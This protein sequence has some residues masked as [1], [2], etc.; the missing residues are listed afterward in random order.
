MN[1]M[2]SVKYRPQNGESDKLPAY[3]S[4][5][6]L[7]DGM[8]SLGLLDGMVTRF[9]ESRRHLLISISMRLGGQEDVW[10][11][12]NHHVARTIVAPVAAESALERLLVLKRI[13][14]SWHKDLTN[15]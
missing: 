7:L 14:V 3:S 10:Y 8:G 2:V 11:T 1:R 13:W 12:V 9:A 5:L 6:I 15:A 4:N